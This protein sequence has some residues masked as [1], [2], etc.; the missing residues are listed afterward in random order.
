MTG[1]ISEAARGS[2]VAEYDPRDVSLDDGIY[3]ARQEDIEAVNCVR[4][5][6]EFTSLGPERS[7]KR[8][9]LVA[10]AK[11]LD[12]ILEGLGRTD[13]TVSGSVTIFDP[14]AADSDRM[15]FN[16]R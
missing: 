14:L 1:A 15:R 8:T 16:Y 6:K 5:T 3:R 2:Y 10:Q 9:V 13:V 4:F 11:H 12:E 7:R